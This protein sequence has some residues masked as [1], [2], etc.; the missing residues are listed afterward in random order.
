MQCV[1]SPTFDSISNGQQAHWTLTFLYSLE[2]AVAYSMLRIDSLPLPSGISPLPA[3]MSG[4]DAT[5]AYLDESPVRVLPIERLFRAAD[6]H[7]G[8]PFCESDEESGVIM[9]G[10]AGS[11]SSSQSIRY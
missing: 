6:V 5:R 11:I 2:S 7:N 9:V 1:Q 4:V 3:E 8:T 10:A